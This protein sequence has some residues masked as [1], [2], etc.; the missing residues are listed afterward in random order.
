MGL[1]PKFREEQVAAI[2]SF[3]R[4]H[5]EDS[6]RKGFLVAM[7][8]GLD[9]TVTAKLCVDAAGATKAKGLMLHDGLTSEADRRDAAA[10]AETLG[11]PFAEVDIEPLVRA[12]A[13]RLPIAPEQR[14]DLGNVKAR[15]RMIVVYHYANVEDRLVIGTGNKSELLTGYFTKFGD[16]GADFLPLGDLYK[17]QVRAMARHL[18]VPKAIVDKVPSAGLWKGQTDEEEL[19][20]GYEDLDAILL[21]IE[22]QLPADA[23]A[24]KTGL[25]LE[26]VRHVEGLVRG[27]IHKRKMPLI[28]KVGVRTIGLDWRE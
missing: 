28:P 17:T 13:D 22:L 12:F 24:D 16:G 25:P 5:L 2:R 11:I 6:G 8:G 1:T 26:K 9:S 10:W 21:G 19:G 3:L 20:I 7:S 27:S 14:R 4:H 15:V 18:G 23:I